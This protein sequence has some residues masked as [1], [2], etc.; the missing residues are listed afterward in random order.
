[1]KSDNLISKEKFE[2]SRIKSKNLIK[3]IRSKYI[4]QIVFNNLEKKKTLDIAK[5]NKNIKE[6]LE[7]DNNDY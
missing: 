6:K 3:I 4:L 2:I 7:I 5:Y 1:M